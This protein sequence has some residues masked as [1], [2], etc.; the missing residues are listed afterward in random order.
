MAPK[1]SQNPA[2]YTAIKRDVLEG[3]FSPGQRL[4]GAT[5]AKR[6]ATSMTPVR[7]AL[8]RLVGERLVEVHA[9]DGYHALAVTQEGLTELYELNGQVL[10]LC[11]KVTKS[12]SMIEELLGQPP[13][14]DGGDAAATLFGAIA[15]ASR[16]TEFVGL[17]TSLNDRLHLARRLERLVSG[18]VAEEI[19]EL[20]T[21]WNDRDL[22]GLR[23]ALGAFHLQRIQQA[24][25]VL[26]LMY[27]PRA[28]S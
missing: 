7:M 9:N 6:H 11:L 17:I 22:P 20:A 19:S 13:N 12:P 18:S 8:S 14:E 21:L 23:A 28:R 16:N 15:A 25:E 24:S 1:G 4:D 10:D 2:V 27:M 5:L 26:K 3:R